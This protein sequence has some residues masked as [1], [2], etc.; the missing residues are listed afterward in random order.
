MKII[1]TIAVC[2]TVFMTGHVQARD[3][4]VGS[5]TIAKIQDSFEKQPRVI[6]GIRTADGE[7]AI[8]C[9]SNRP[10]MRMF[11]LEGTV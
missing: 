7:F 6:A 10:F 5:W 4:R 11:F 2:C 9:E 8:T 3:V 1:R